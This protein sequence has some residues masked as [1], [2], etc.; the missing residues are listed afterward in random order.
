MCSWTNA[1]MMKHPQCE[2]NMQ[3]RKIIYSICFIFLLFLFSC[4][5]NNDENFSASLSGANEMP[6]VT[7]SAT[8]TATFTHHGNDKSIDYFLNVSN[9]SGAFSAHIHQGAAGENG[10]IVAT[11]F[12]GPVT[13][14]DFSGRLASGT[15]QAFS[16]MSFD[17]LIASMK[18]GQV[19]V[20]VHTTQNQQGEIRGQIGR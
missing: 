2:A 15:L 9:I 11:L 5:E 14:G 17:Q 19:Y 12:N 8:G 7:T 13:S 6:A 10:D 16:G 3:E 1:A 20:D 18:S 4:S